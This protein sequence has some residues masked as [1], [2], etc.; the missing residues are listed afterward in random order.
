M[1][2]FIN[3]D[4]FV[5]Q[6]HREPSAK[7]S[8]RT[9]GTVFVRHILECMVAA[10]APR[11]DVLRA[12][13]LSI[14]ELANDEG[15]VAAEV[16]L[17]MWNAAIAATGDENLGLRCATVSSAFDD[18]LIL[19]IMRTSETLGGAI[20]RAIRYQRLNQDVASSTLAIRGSIARFSHS[21][22]EAVPPIPGPAIELGFG[23]LLRFIREVVGQDFVPLSVA[24]EHSA[25]KDL[26][27]HHTIFGRNVVFNAP[28][29]SI[30]FESRWLEAPLK[31]TDSPLRRI[32]ERYADE[33]LGPSALEPSI[34][35]M[36]RPALERMLRNGDVSLSSAAK[37]VALSSRS[38]QRKLRDADTTFVGVLDDV[39][40]QLL[41]AYISDVT[42]SLA[43]IAYL[44]GFSN[45]SGFHR[46][47]IR[48]FGV[49]PGRWRAQQSKL[50]SRSGFRGN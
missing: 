22:R 10:G 25:P 1:H 27:L 31:T 45:Q 37:A 36:L 44:L 50:G 14:E 42:L 29:N 5:A 33:V 20:D 3:D 18:V 41:Q 32:L 46:A 7:L 48:W 26:S 15:R 13:N 12:A 23:A 38:L 9:I 30:E 24:L 40:K 17:C 49:T 2:S 16:D 4:V 35:R 28:E 34:V 6:A 39:R 8:G 21:G 47:F 43:Q 19:Y 11:E